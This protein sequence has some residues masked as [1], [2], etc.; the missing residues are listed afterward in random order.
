MKRAIVRRIGNSLGIVIPKTQ[1]A[2][3]GLREGDEVDIEIRKARHLEDVWGLL[4]GKL[5]DVDELN[6]LVDE[7]EDVA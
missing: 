6:R 3:E 5:G 4:R 1:A 7:G 2:A